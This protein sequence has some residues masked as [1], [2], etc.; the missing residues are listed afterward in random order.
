MFAKQY[1]IP[2]VNKNFHSFINFCK[3][4]IFHNAPNLKEEVIYFEGLIRL[5]NGMAYASLLCLL[6]ASVANFFMRP[7]N[8]NLFLLYSILL[9]T[10]TIKIRHMRCREVVHTF[11]S[12]VVANGIRICTTIYGRSK[13]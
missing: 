2:I 5:L 6:A 10:F 3:T 11:D 13:R 7:I 8:G 9:F 1:S 4:F 12:F